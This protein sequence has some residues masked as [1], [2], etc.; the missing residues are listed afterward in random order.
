MTIGPLA[1][2]QSWTITITLGPATTCINSLHYGSNSHGVFDLVPIPLAGQVHIAYDFINSS[3]CPNITT[4]F[5]TSAAASSSIDTA[6]STTHFTTSTTGSA[7]SVDSST[8]TTHSISD[9]TSTSAFTISDS[10][11]STIS[12]STS[13]TSNSDTITTSTTGG[14][15]IHCGNGIVE[16][17][18][19]EECD[20]NSPCCDSCMFVVKGI[21]CRA[22]RGECDEVD[23]CSGVDD[24]CFGILFILFNT[25]FFITY[26]A[27]TQ[28]TLER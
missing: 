22:S 2:N 3:Y 6:S 17:E 21:E 20:S 7:T 23:Y 5:T 13:A 28:L 4:N 10:T 24:L 26:F 14:D 18:I 25:L 16:T 8:S 11:S 27:K 1:Q 15:I 19:G 12:S 9:S